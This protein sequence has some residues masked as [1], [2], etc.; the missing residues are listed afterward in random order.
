[1]IT[2][3]IHANV[4]LNV[5]TNEMI[6]YQKEILEEQNKQTEQNEQ[7]SKCVTRGP[8]GGA[9]RPF[10]AGSSVYPPIHI[11]DSPC[12]SGKTS[13]MINHIRQDKSGSKYIYVTPIL[14]EVKRVIR[15]CPQQH[16]TEPQARNKYGSKFLD[17]L[18]KIQSKKNIVTS[19]SLFHMFTPVTMQLCSQNDYILVLDEAFDVVTPYRIGSHDFETILEKYAH[20]DEET[21]LLIW[22][23]R[24]Y[25]ESDE[26]LLQVKNLCD[27]HS[28]FVYNANGVK[29]VF[30]WTFPVEIFKAFK[31]VY[32]LT[33]MF[34][35]Q[36]QAYYY[37][38]FNVPFTQ[39]YVKCEKPE[40]AIVEYDYSWFKFTKEPQD[41]RRNLKDL[42]HIYDGKL[43]GI[44]EL[45]TFS[46]SWYLKSDVDEQANIFRE[47][48]Q[49]NVYNY[50]FHVVSC[51][52]SSLNL[53]TTFKAYKTALSGKGYTK[54]FLA[55]NAR[56]T[57]DYRHKTQL[58]YLIN[59]FPNPVIKNF[60]TV[61][62]IKINEDLYALSE[63]I[64]WI[65]RSAI[66]DDKPI[67]I[68]VPCRRMRSLLQQYI[69]NDGD[70]SFLLNRIKSVN[71]DMNDED[72]DDEEDTEEIYKIFM[73]EM[74]LSE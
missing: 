56:A 37:H 58:A 65:Y 42:I 26:T 8:T 6:E 59:V 72:E 45:C 14:D 73:E 63:M 66:R 20:I 23:D 28:L 53:W 38:F 5:A 68:Y 13:C 11:V 27:A 40:D 35:G 47:Q 61:R 51:R 31:E 16:F 15:S 41:D 74:E 44:G 55:C 1:M 50:F 17:V 69:N 32:V 43:N 71:E 9:S 33:Y 30:M 57:N 39:L 48:L 49:N 29:R 34:E 12:G 4:N 21:N 22:D 25:K 19:H 3:E 60:F 67:E 36:I 46:K 18:K 64:Q 24:T 2:D 70:Y 62:E 52:N 54:G 7:K 10:F